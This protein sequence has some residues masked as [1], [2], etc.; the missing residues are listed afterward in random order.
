[1]ESSEVDALQKHLKRIMSIRA[2]GRGFTVSDA[3]VIVLAP[4][5]L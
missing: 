3:A 5:V 1:M 4:C 2:S